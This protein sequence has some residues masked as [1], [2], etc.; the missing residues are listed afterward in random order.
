MNNQ[1][2]SGN[3]KA[4][5]AKVNS[6]VEELLPV[7][8]AY[9]VSKEMSIVDAIMVVHNVHK[10]IVKGIAEEWEKQGIPYEKTLRMAD[11]TFRSS[12]KELRRSAPTLS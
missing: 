2:V 11:M 8:T 9:M 5:M 12:M 3:I 7:I 1:V 10:I 6:A 4:D